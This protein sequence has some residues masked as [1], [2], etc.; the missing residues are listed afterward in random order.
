MSKT[1]GS[2]HPDLERLSELLEEVPELD[3]RE[4]RRIRLHLADCA[5][6]R[7]SFE[8]LSAIVAAARELR[9]PE[10]PERIWQSISKSLPTRG[11][12][13]PS[14]S[15]FYPVLAAAATLVLGLSIWLLL[16]SPSSAPA[17]TAAEQA[18]LADLVTEELKA[19]EAHYDK[20]IAG[21]EQIIAQ[22]QGVLPGEIAAVLNQ[23]LDLIENAIAESR[24]AI[25]SDPQSPMAQ[26]SLLSALRSKVALLQNTILL[27]N[28]VRKGEGEAALDRIDEMRKSN[29]PGNPI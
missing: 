13:R 17:S 7:R 14:R 25:T 10:P 20:A 26:E 19:A 12:S 2:E 18:E 3:P 23:N 28:E 22:N 29:T 11:A 15:W 21:L 6:C 24:T 4:E 8:E 27:I 16:R 9:A 5:D 1:T